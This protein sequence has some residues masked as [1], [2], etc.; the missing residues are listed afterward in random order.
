M[1][2]RIYFL[3]G[4]EDN[5]GGGAL[6]FSCSHWFPSSSNGQAFSLKKKKKKLG[7]FVC[8]LSALGNPINLCWVWTDRICPQYCDQQ[9]CLTFWKCSAIGESWHL[10]VAS[11]P[12]WA[13]L[14]LHGPQ[15][16]VSDAHP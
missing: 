6:V 4:S 16:A 15:G 7:I 3:R 14:T 9:K 5:V 12:Y 2:P 11:S 8:T 13:S 10:G 1:F